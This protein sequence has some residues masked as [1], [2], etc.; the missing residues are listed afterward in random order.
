MSG[1][2]SLTSFGL[3]NVR[4]LLWDHHPLCFEAFPIIMC[5]FLL[6]SSLLVLDE[7]LDRYGE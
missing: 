1:V 5:F 4:Q 2:Q 6:G 7:S 3:D